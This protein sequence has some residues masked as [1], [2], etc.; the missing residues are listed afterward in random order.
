MNIWSED[1]TFKVEW[2]QLDGK[3]QLRTTICHEKN[4]GK[5]N[6]IT[7]ENQAIKEAAAY[8]T[9]KIKSGYSVDP[10]APVTVSLPMKVQTYSKHKAKVIFPCY[11]SP[12]LNG[13]NATYKQNS[14]I[15]RLLSRG[16]EDYPLVDQQI[17]DILRILKQLNTDELNGELYIHGEHLQNITGA[18]KKYR[19][20][21]NK[22]EFHIFDIPNIPGTYEDRIAVMRTI[23]DTSFVKVV[24]AA[25]A[26][27]HDHLDE[28]HDKYVT[29]GYEGLVVRNPEG[30]YK[31]NSRSNDV[32][33]LKKA[34]DAEF[35]IAGFDTD[36]ND[37][38]V[39]HLTTAEGKTFK[40]KPKGERLYRQNL[41]KNGVS[42]IGDW[43]TVEYETLSADGIPL[44][45]VALYPRECDSKGSPVE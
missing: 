45:P 27:N 15:L 41:A 10:A 20:L 42:H 13:V 28:L 30:L 22:L 37:E 4:I 1:G 32:F 3:Q 5:S 9:K 14:K 17:D 39:W 33:K 11:E 35:K 40:A 19:E 23:K 2:G 36:K 8:H 7:P 38:V 24:P 43:W 26:F 18:V 12:K 16:G 21:S 25:K 6:Y 34:L 31:H 29:Q 44:K